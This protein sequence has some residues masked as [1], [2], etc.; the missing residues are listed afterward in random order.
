MVRHAARVAIVGNTIATLASPL[1]PSL[2][3]VFVISF[4]FTRPLALGLFPLG[5]GGTT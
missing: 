4:W 2:A 5:R 1:I 3:L